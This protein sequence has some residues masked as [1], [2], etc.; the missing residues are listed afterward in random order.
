MENPGAMKSHTIESEE[1]KRKWIYKRKKRLG[2]GKILFQEGHAFFK[3][4]IG[5]S[6]MAHTFSTR[7]SGSGGQEDS[8]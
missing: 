7:C 5:I 4:S 6:V 1:I 8:D 3:V 2:S